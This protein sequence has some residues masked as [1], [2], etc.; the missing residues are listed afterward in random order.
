MF[1]PI[2]ASFNIFSL[3]LF[4]YSLGMICLHVDLLVFILLCIL[5]APWIFHLVSDINF[6][7]FSAN[8]SL[9][10]SSVPFSLS[11]PFV[12]PIKTTL[13]LQWVSHSSWIFVPFFPFSP[14]LFAFQFGKFL[15]H[16]FKVTDSSAVLSLLISSSKAFFISVSQI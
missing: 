11:S 2:L 9:S 5:W 1:P 14:F 16:L 3:F 4:F 12:I 15:W 13:H 6:R 7:K 10:I 8:I